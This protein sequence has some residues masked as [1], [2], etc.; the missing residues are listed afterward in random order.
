VTWRLKT[1]M[2]ANINMKTQRLISS[3]CFRF[4][5]KRGKASMSLIWNQKT[6]SRGIQYFFLFVYAGN[7]ILCLC[8]CTFL[9]VHDQM[10]WEFFQTGDERDRNEGTFFDCD[11]ISVYCK[12]FSNKRNKLLSTQ[13]SCS[14]ATLPNRTGRQTLKFTF[15]S[16][17]EEMKHRS[18]TERRSVKIYITTQKISVFDLL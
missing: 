14:H 2:A 6:K 16:V 11:F 8:E 9:T 4:F 12:Y 18:L 10:R 3:L 5:V 17:K 7:S 1:L 15:L 13:Y